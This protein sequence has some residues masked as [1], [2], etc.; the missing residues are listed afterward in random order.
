[1]ATSLLRKLIQYLENS[2]I[3]SFLIWHWT[4]YEEYS[5]MSISFLTAPRKLK[6]LPLRKSLKYIKK[7][8][9][10]NQCKI[11][12]SPGSCL[13]SQANSQKTDKNPFGDNLFLFWSFSLSFLDHSFKNFNW[14]LFSVLFG[15]F[16]ILWIFHNVNQ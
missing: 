15:S 14:M 7:A 5:A 4:I 1:M 9:V 10:F 12:C 16:T 11:L 2:S 8:Y 13:I 3:R 6:F